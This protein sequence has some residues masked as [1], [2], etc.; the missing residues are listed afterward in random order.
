LSGP[1]ADYE[2]STDPARL[3]RAAIHRYLSE[4][5]YWCPGIPREVV[6]RSIDNSLCFGLF[7]PDGSQA[8]FGRAVT[9]RATYAWLMD[10]FVLPEHRG[11]GLGKWLVET[12]LAHSAL[13]GLRHIGLATTDAHELYA[14]YGFERPEDGE[15]RMGISRDPRDLYGA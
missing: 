10:I 11:R 9:D 3:D 1:R 15:Q 7:A 14:R 5:A 6:D 4:E 2:I 13:Q 12:M 8:G